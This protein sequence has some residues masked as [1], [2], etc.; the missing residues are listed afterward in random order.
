VKN[1]L[2]GPLGQQSF[3]GLGR[4]LSVDVGGRITTF[5][6]QTGQLPPSANTLPDDKRIDF[7]YEPKLDDRLLTIH[8]VGEAANSFTYH[9][10]LG[11][12]ASVSGPLGKH[13]MTYTA[14]GKPL[15]DTWEVDSKKHVTT[16]R[17]SLNSLLLGFLDANDTDHQ[18]HHDD[19]GRLVKVVTGNVIAEF[20]YDDFSRPQVLTTT[21][22]SNS[23]R[24]IQTLT[25]D[26]LGREHTRTFAATVGSATRTSVQTLTY[27]DL[28]QLESRHWQDA[29]RQGKETFAYD[30]RGRLTTYTAEPGVAPEDPFGNRIIKQEF[31]LNF[32]DGYDQV[33][34]TFADG[35]EDTAQ[36][37]YSN[38][39]D[40]TQVSAISHTHPRPE[41]I[42]LTYDACGRVIADSL[43]RR[44]TWDAQD[45]LIRVDYLG[46]LCRY[47]Y[48][49][50]G[51]LSDRV[52]DGE[53]SR[54]FF[55][56][57]QLTHEQTAN[58]VLERIGDGGALF[59]LNRITNGVRQRTTLLGSDAQGSVR[60]EADSEVRSRHYTAHGAEP[61]AEANS[62]YGYTGERREPLSG[63]YIPAGYRPYDP[64]LM[65]FL[66]PDSESPFGRGGLNP[67]AYCGGA[68][69]NRVD[70]DG[71]AWWTWVLVGVGTALGIAAVVASFGTAAPAFAAIAVGNFAALTA[72]GVTAMG[73]TTLGAISVASGAA[74]TLMEATGK[75]EKAASALGWI[76]LGTG[77]AGNA[78][79]IAPA[80]A[81]KLATK[82]GRSA[83]RGAKKFGAEMNMA[84]GPGDNLTL[85]KDNS[86][87]ISSLW[88]TE[89]P[90]YR[91]HGHVTQKIVLN[92]NGA[93][94]SPA[95]L[96]SDLSPYMQQF[97]PD[98]PLVLV[99][100]KA[101]KTGFA[102]DLANEMRRPI[103]A[104]NEEAWTKTSAKSLT[105]PLER[106]Q[107]P[108]QRNY[109]GNRIKRPAQDTDQVI[110]V[111]KGER[112]LRRS[113]PRL[114]LPDNYPPIKSIWY[115]VLYQ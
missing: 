79:E 89:L 43:G 100:C 98:T 84:W 88:G 16:W 80:A 87:F 21:D 106:A 45:R 55:S 49:P 66:S 81:V 111:A 78:L 57:G 86:A 108:G 110:P 96:A 1:L 50:S 90:A 97:S 3:D 115:N 4:Q 11:L 24:L 70:P 39:K 103:I 17:F 51:N 15:K 63:W 37:T 30:L 28:D 10:D 101:G 74:G 5:E 82:L 46:K 85:G 34:S 29:T 23:N 109:L 33:V 31:T 61:E 59:A 12:T 92:M 77:L 35:S 83:G 22:S 44:M 114:F 71:H 107:A 27:T 56:G 42:E 67:Y 25:Y 94:S 64:L 38:A 112:D 47:A 113:M 65:I 40:P 95:Q 18:R 60:I 72:S 8:P 6:Y 102:K 7:T 91:A 73:V 13:E 52:L 53:L 105:T 58:Q 75:D 99:V 54:S 62:P 41:R 9:K 69:V 14:S 26:S 19:L 93:R 20:T 76:S 2:F 68:P 48:D 36:Y 32:L 104:F